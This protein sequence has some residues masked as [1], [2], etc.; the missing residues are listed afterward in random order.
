MTARFPQS[1]SSVAY[2][3][4]AAYAS[5][6]YGICWA[7]SADS[8]HRLHTGD[9]A[10]TIITRAASGASFDAANGRITGNSSTLFT[11][12]VSGGIA[13]LRENSDF[14]LGAVYFGDQFNGVPDTMAIGTTAPPDSFNNGSKFLFSGNVCYIGTT[15]IST[16]VGGFSDNADKAIVFAYRNAQGDA[17]AK[18]RLWANGA[19]VTAARTNAAPSSTSLIGDTSRPLYF[20]GT[21]QHGSNPNTKLQFEMMFIGSGALTDAEMAAITADPSVLIEA[22]VAD[23][24]APVMTGT[25]MASGVSSTG[26]TLDWSGTTRSDNIA[27]GGYQHSVNGTTWTDSGNVTSRS[28]TG[29]SA[30]TLYPNYVRAYDTASPPNYSTPALLLNVTTAAPA[31]DTAA[32]NLS[33]AITQG[34][35]TSS[36]STISWPAATD[37]VGVDHY[38]V[39]KDGGSTWV[40]VSASTLTYTFTG[41][42][43]STTYGQRVRAMD[44]AGNASSVLALAVTT[45]AA[46]AAVNFA[47]SG[48]MK[49]LNG[50]VIPDGAYTVMVRSK[51]VFSV[52][53]LAVKTGLAVVN[54]VAPAFSI[55]GPVAGTEYIYEVVNEAD[56]TIRGAARATPT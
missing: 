18:Q 5:K 7:A 12:F 56:P 33:G 17:T 53:P 15:T 1:A 27:I 49:N 4:A 3:I 36:T 42:S 9:N 13:G 23:T 29:K 35:I 11:D 34:A 6:I 19:E 2:R 55:G 46:S 47:A 44:L 31:G 54:G 48:Q 16:G 30:S 39:S 14:T 51:T 37:N 22:Y 52:A 40:S 8:A 45:S 24:T 25:M 50:S 32:P 20:G 41:L 21:C 43:A 28:F 26:Y 38:E 10:T